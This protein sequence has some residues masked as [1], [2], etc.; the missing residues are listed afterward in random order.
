M[1]AQAAAQTPPQRSLQKVLRIGVVQEGKVARERLM[2]IQ[3]LVTIGDGPRAT[4]TVLGTQ[5]GPHH[6]LFLPKGDHYVLAVPEWVEGKL[7]WK[8]GIRGLD[9]LRGRGD[10]VKKGDVWHLPLTD[11][12]KGK[13]TVGS[14]TILFQFV[15]AP[16]EPVRPISPADFKRPMLDDEDPLFLG[17]LGVFSV[18][19]V[20]FMLYVYTTPRV[21]NEDVIDMEE[22][23]KLVKTS[24]IPI[25]VKPADTAGQEK[26]AEKS[27]K[28]DQK[29][30]DK[31]A[32]TAGESKPSAPSAD[33]VAK[34]SLLLQMFGT[35]ADG[36]GTAADLIGDDAAQAKLDAALSG[37]SGAQQASAGDLGMKT[38]GTG[39]RGD[40]TVGVGVATGGSAGTGGGVATVVK[41]PKVD[42]GSADASVDEGDGSGIA[43]TM[44]K[45][46]G[47]VASCVEQGLKQDPE[48]SGRVSV[49]FQITKGKVSDVH[50]VD[51]TTGNS[52]VGTCIAGAIR[53]IRFAEDLTATV[54]EYPFIVSGQ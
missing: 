50:V 45:S 30:A 48:M 6:E 44:R 54:A 33:S 25:E 34:K 47:R 20:A 3:E 51:N 5:I 4:F 46:S 49:G 37:V 9:E 32:E 29:K 26:K 40:A 28:K 38:G 17:L 42:Y 7:S 35:V 36:N 8:D 11:N 41:K 39:G 53:G 13:V 21:A 27:E 1:S 24:P 22:L 10:A 2:R 43:G 18:I 16:P 14:T 23:S 12:V 52:Q 19:A 15:Q 31:P